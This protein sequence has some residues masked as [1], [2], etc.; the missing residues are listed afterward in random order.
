MVVS[1]FPVFSLKWIKHNLIHYIFP[2]LFKV[3]YSF[4]KYALFT[5]WVFLDGWGVAGFLVCVSME[6]GGVGVMFSC[7]LFFL[8]LTLSVLHAEVVK[9]N[10]T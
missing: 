6:K 1:T 4:W 8:P 2:I 10:I 7:F 9:V 3:N 5:L